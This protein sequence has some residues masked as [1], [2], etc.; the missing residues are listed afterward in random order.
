M[1][2]GVTMP[3]CAWVAALKALQNSMILTPRWPSAGPTGGLGFACPAG[4]CN[5]ISPITFF[6]IMILSFELVALH[7]DELELNRGRTT[8]YADQ[9]SELALVR[10]DLFDD[11]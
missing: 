7:L 1:I 10:L 2:T 9:N 8:K 11:T 6:A 5:L 4:I 3:T